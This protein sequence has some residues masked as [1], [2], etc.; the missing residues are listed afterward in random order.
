MSWQEELNK[1]LEAQREAY[2]E[3]IKSGET[4]KRMQ[5]YKGKI[6]S[7]TNIKNRKESGYYQSDE[8]KELCKI[9]A[10][11]RM[12]NPNFKKEQSEF[13]KKGGPKGGKT[14]G[15]INAKNGHMQKMHAVRKQ[16]SLELRNSIYGKL[17]NQFTYNDGLNM[18]IELG[19][20]KSLFHKLIYDKEIFDKIKIDKILNYKKKGT[21]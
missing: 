19:Y 4:Q 12:N 5:S 8:F 14:Q 11:A 9:A 1:K 2:K 16:K 17:P 21:I 15:D 7:N 20:S 13:G 6:G 10:S 3:S 18:V